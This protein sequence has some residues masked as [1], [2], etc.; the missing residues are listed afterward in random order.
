MSHF[1]TTKKRSIVKKKL[2]LSALCLTISGYSYSAVPAS[3]FWWNPTEGGRGWTIETQNGYMFIATY[4]YDANGKAIFFTSQGEYSETI[5]GLQGDFILTQGGQC[6]GCVYSAPSYTLTGKVTFKFSDAEHGQV[7]T[8]KGTIPIER[9]N[10]LYGTTPAEKIMGGWDLTYGANGIYFGDV[11]VVD[12]KD[13]TIEGGFSGHRDGS[14]RLLVGAPVKGTNAIL[15]LLDSSSSYYTQYLFI[16][17]LNTIAGKSWTYLKTESPPTT[18]GL[19]MVGHRIADKTGRAVILS[20]PLAIDDKYD[21]IRSEIASGASNKKEKI[22]EEIIDL[23]Y[24][25]KKR[26]DSKL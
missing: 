24:K 9:M 6:I 26:L 18:S 15:I 3:G 17:T 2:K 5:G 12:K 11:L 1:F 10:Y 20:T 14:S 22:D 16:P 23:S 7:I 13:D 21:A 4:A 25:L 19:E 8:E